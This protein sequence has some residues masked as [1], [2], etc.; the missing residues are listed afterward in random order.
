MVYIFLGGFVVGLFIG[1]GLG[2]FI[3]GLTSIS[4]QKSREEEYAENVKTMFRIQADIMS[5]NIDEA[6]KNEK[7]LELEELLKG[8]VF[9]ILKRD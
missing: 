5:K 4:S 3:I 6:R 1:C 7:D 2:F 9:E 8:T